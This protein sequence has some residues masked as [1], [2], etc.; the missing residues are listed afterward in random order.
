MAIV[1]EY[2]T[3]KTILKFFPYQGAACVVPQ[4]LGTDVDG[5]KIVK[6]G[7]PIPSNDAKALGLLLADVDV[8]EGDAAGT[9]VYEGVIDP[10]KLTANG[11]TVADAAKTALPRVTFYGEAHGTTATA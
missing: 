9:Y 6:A 4:S 7:T 10:D 8:T 3:G 5:K 2:D 1:N 11:V